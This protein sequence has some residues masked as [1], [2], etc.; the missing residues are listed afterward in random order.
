M[1][2]V[3]TNE[4]DISI[5]R[6]KAVLFAIRTNR[7]DKINE[8]F[9]HLTPQEIAAILN[10]IP[11]YDR[12]TLIKSLPVQISP[13]VINYLNSKVRKQVIH[14]LDCNEHIEENEET[15]IEQ[16]ID[17]YTL[18][19]IKFLANNDYDGVCKIFDNLQPAD[20]AT[21]L[22]FLTQQQRLKVIKVLDNKF[23]AKILTFIDIGIREDMLN[24]MDRQTVIHFMASLEYTDII[25]ILDNLDIHKQTEILNGISSLVDRD[26][27]K[28]IRKN[29]FY[30]EGTAGRI[31]TPGISF[32][33][34]NTV[35]EVYNRFCFNP[36]IPK[37]NNLIYI[38]D[39]NKD[40]KFKLIGS[41]YIADLCR[42][43]KNKYFRN[44]NISEHMDDIACIL[45]TDTKLERIAFLF[46]KYFVLQMPVVNPKNYRL[47]GVISANQ[48]I[49]I[50]DIYI[51][52]KILSLGGLDV[53]DFHE[54]ITST[55]TTRLKWLSIASMA[56]I[57]STIVIHC[58]EDIIKNNSFLG[59]IMPIAP[60]IGGNAASQVLTIT[61]R[62]L[63]NGEI[64][65]AN[66]YRTIKKEIISNLGSGLIIGLC[67][68]IITF[69]YYKKIRIAFILSL[70]LITNITWAGL[71]A[72]AIP[73]ILDRQGKDATLTSVFLTITTDMM[74]YLI[75]FILVK[76]IL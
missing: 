25:D 29:L 49:D 27:F 70:A 42:L 31:M 5:N 30:E 44:Q 32:S 7:M 54:S 73:I 2:L 46:K 6:L 14:E 19:T 57:L 69:L 12:K 1:P 67:I 62:A 23:D 75:F 17:K 43:N 8:I 24:Q 39:M 64:G 58:F 16:L 11:D 76:L 66:L 55:I 68:G 26:T 71:V 37:E 3:K 41:V 72:S 36:K 61:I 56:T 9:V 34:S 13:K 18:Q 40:N 22:E 52:D 4:S 74:G 20:A 51:G 35:K 65:Q 10:N 53:F 21:I 15:N 33:G 50:L 38:H 28:A 59:V 45:K 60:A 63:S 48:A 47:M